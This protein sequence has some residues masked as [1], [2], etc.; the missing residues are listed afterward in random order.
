[1]QFTYRDYI[2]MIDV[3]KSKEYTFANYHNSDNYDKAVILRHD[4]DTSIDKALKIAEIEYNEGVKSTFFI[5]LATK[6]YNI[7]EKDTLK[8]IKEISNLGHEIGL[9]FDE[10]NYCSDNTEE[11][12]FREVDVMSKLIERNVNVVSMHRPSKKTLAADYKLQGKII[13][14]YGKKFFNEYKY[15]SDSRHR[16]RENVTEVIKNGS[17]LKLHILTHPF[18]YNQEE[19]SLNEALKE[20]VQKASE[21][22]Y[23]A[24][25][26]N[27]TDLEKE[28]PRN[29][30]VLY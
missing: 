3:L 7:A 27:I 16:W 19:I 25:C 29:E 14:S 28:L 9:H 8:M 26:D 24:L 1:M 11:L 4:V 10:A 2:Q 6:F 18:W 23:M 20:F 5:L 17:Y 22:R 12:I 21:E 15:V 13:N 30:A